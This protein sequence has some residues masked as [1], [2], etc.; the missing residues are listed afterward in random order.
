MPSLIQTLRNGCVVRQDTKEGQGMTQFGRT[1]SE[2]D[3][4]ILCAN[5]SQAKAASK[6][7]T[8]RC[9]TGL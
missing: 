2:L 4:A 6:V 8:A 9:R 1:L 7:P 5:S 3:I